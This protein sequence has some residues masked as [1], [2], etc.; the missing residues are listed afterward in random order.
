VYTQPGIEL[1]GD[2]LGSGTAARLVLWK[3]GGPVVIRGA[4]AN[5]DVRTDGCPPA[6]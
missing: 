4:H 6:G 2:M 1:D 5:E 3:V